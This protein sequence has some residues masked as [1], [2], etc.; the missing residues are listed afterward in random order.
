M[1]LFL[2]PDELEELTGY[3]M[4]SKQSMWLQK[5]DWVFEISRLGR[6]KVLREYAKMRLGMPFDAPPKIIEPAFDKIP[7]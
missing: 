4:R 7:T 5:R 6:V 3:S 2:T 1:S